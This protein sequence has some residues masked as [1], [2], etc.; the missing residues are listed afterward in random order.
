VTVGVNQ[1]NQGRVFSTPQLRA[2]RRRARRVRVG[3]SAR[4]RH[5]NSCDHS[6]E[7]RQV[8]N[9]SR[10]GVYFVTQRQNYR[11]H[12]HL[13]VV[14]PDSESRGDCEREIGR[15]VRIDSLAD[16]R[17]GVAVSFLRSPVFH[18]TGGLQ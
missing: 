15:V 1:P 5:Y 10:D 13:Y 18:S 14:C 6:E 8:M 17:W 11:E 3:M 16:G 12:M 9:M 2:D 7:I 4:I